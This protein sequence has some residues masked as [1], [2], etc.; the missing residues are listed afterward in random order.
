MTFPKDFRWGVAT[1]SYQIEGASTEDGR[2][3]SIWD[4]FCDT[5]GK[6]LNA[7][8][9]DVACEHYHRYPQDVA[10]MKEIGV[11]TYRFSTA[12]SR[13]LPEGV[14]R[15]EPRGLDFYDR[16][17]DELL[18][19]NITPFLTIFHWDLPQALQD[20]GGWTNRLVLDGWEQY[21]NLLTDKLGDRVKNWMTHNEPW[22]SSIL[23]HVIG[24]HAPGHT[25]WKE[26]LAA[27]HHILVTHGI[28]MKILREKVKDG[29]HG[30]ALNLNP[31]YANNDSESAQLAVQRFDGYF[32]RWFLDPI[33]KGEYPAD[34]WEFYGA[35][36]PT[37][38]DGDMELISQPIDFLGV[39]YYS[40]ALFNGINE[41][42]PQIKPIDKLKLEYART[43]NEYTFM[44]WEVFPQG[45]YDL[46]VRVHQDYAPKA[47]LITENGCA[48]PDELVGDS[49]HDER[50]VAYYQAHI[51][52]CERMINDGVPLVGYFAWSLMDNF[53]WAWGYSRRFGI[54]Y[55]DYATQKRTLKDSAKWYQQHITSLNAQHAKA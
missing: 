25:D 40:R 13:I 49:V 28:A 29:S 11:S 34:M 1:S 9:G 26:G 38:V 27:A 39:N 22:C 7:D 15:V 8:N 41:N 44:D 42:L 2:G 19:Q 51:A 37:I 47:L 50:R 36:V 24:E 10:L 45:L 21:V 4:V 6:V 3:A 20:K 31:A 55:V 17:V 5:P 18:K 54:T 23:S 16:L 12:W 32:N 52:E 33:F 53:E 35:D 43:D 46:F 48:Y 30:I 14:G